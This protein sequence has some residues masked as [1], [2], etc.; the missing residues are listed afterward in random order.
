MKKISS[1]LIIISG[2]LW[3]SMG[4]F[5]RQFNNNGLFS[6]EV[7]GIRSFG[8]GLIITVVLFFWKR[9][10]LKIKP[11]D[12]WIFLG[13]GLLSVLCFNYCYFRTI[14]LTSMTIAA[15]LLYTS[16][17]IVMVLAILIFKESL[18]LA[19]ILAL[20]ISFAGCVL[21]S[22]VIGGQ[23]ILTTEGLLMGLGSGLA[24]ALYTIFSR[25]GLERGYH[26]LTI[27]AYTFIIA[28]LG[29][30]P[31]C[32]TGKIIR[33]I[34]SDYKMLL[35]AATFAVISTVLPYFLY[36]IAL[37]HT[38]SGKAAI[39]ASTEPVAAAIFGVL[40]YHEKMTANVLAGIICVLISVLILNIRFSVKLTKSGERLM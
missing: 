11:R 32:D 9:E 14:S 18:T 26:P 39:M 1:L 21:V 15:V 17:I 19:K 25:F 35:M 5:V 2:I 6:M 4:I 33:V 40:L 28:G 27:V 24:Y 22:G 8:A 36:T 37:S 10:L 38:E 34:G 13:S 20:C 23:T 31:I 12:I 30:L 7:S 29:I 16:P 3:G